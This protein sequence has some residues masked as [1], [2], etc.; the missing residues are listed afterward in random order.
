MAIVLLVRHAENDYVKEGRLAGRIPEVH[1]NEKGREQ[2]ERLAHSFQHVP[3]E[4]VYSSPLERAMETAY[5]ITKERKLNIQQEQALNE[6]DFGDLQ[7]EKI[8]N[9]RKTNLW[10]KMR[11]TPSL[12]R[13]PNGET[14]F[15]AQQRAVQFIDMLR[16]Q[17]NKTQT[18]V[19][20]THA[21]IIK[22]I[23]I[24]F[25]GLPLDSFRRID[26]G[27]ATITAFYIDKHDFRLMTLASPSIC[28]IL[29]C[30]GK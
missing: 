22:L 29:P 21:D 18:V 5:Y 23:V 9:L 11:Q 10:K 30:N 20:V 14:F 13:F 4:A 19:C 2:G 17:W 15:E 26:I 24:Y 6:I 16:E 12:I 3:F 28:H 1:L 25:L 27:T 7:G 8:S